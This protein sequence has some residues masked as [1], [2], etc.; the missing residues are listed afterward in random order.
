MWVL[1]L[2]N[3]HQ[4]PLAAYQKMYLFL[5]GEELRELP[6]YAKPPALPEFP[7]ES[8]KASGDFLAGKE[9]PFLSLTSRQLKSHREK[10]DAA[11]SV[12]AIVRLGSL[13]ELIIHTNPVITSPNGGCSLWCSRSFS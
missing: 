1:I 9:G 10:M 5:Q 7:L 8:P 11:V 4:P 3:A 2:F 13:L 6:L 12:Y